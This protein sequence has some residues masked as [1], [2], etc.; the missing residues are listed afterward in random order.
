VCSCTL[1]N[2]ACTVSSLQ[3]GISL[4]G[5]C[6]P[7]GAGIGQLSKAN[8]IAVATP[9]ANSQFAAV[10]FVSYGANG[11][12]S[13]YA[14]PVLL[15][16]LNGVAI[17]VPSN[18]PACSAGGY[19]ACNAAGTNQFV[20]APIVVTG[21]APYD[22]VLAFADRNTLVSMLGNGSCQTVW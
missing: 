17:P 5:M 15:H 18:Y 16:G 8:S 1:V 3:A 12:G 14:S 10:I 7:S 4:Q 2:N 13:F 21:N 20:D 9:G 11:Y 22:D 6:A 19:A